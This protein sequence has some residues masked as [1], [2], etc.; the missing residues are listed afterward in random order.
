MGYRG[1]K[2]NGRSGWTAL[3]KGACARV[4]LCVRALRMGTEVCALAELRRHG[5]AGVAQ[6]HAATGVEA[7][8]GPV[9]VPCKGHLR[10][11]EIDR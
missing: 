10:G 11:R 9:A 5:V 4:C 2:K 3:E 8:Q 1:K 7:P 6:Q